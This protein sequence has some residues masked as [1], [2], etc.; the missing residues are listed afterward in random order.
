VRR[1]NFLERD[2]V[3]KRT[4]NA[5]KVLIGS[6]HAKPVTTAD[7][8]SK[9]PAPG[10]DKIGQR[11]WKRI[12][13]A[14]AASGRLTSLDE[15]LL[16][17]YCSAYSRWRRAEAK[18][19]TEGEVVMVPVRDTHG[20]EIFQKPVANPLLKVVEMSARQVHRFGEALGLSPASRIKQGIEL[21]AADE[22]S[23]QSI[24]DLLKKEKA[25]SAATS[26]LQNQA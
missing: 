14:F 19:L 15:S 21:K 17:L 11:E 4:S 22:Y 8:L 1:E 9:R 12:R 3:P 26:E 16:L 24:F 2:E 18:L 13:E 5:S 10:L 6:A 7:P 23:G 25:K 20:H